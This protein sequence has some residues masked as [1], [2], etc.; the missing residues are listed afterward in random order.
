[1]VGW[2]HRLDE[3]GFGKTP[4]LGVGGGQGGLACCGHTFVKA[5]LSLYPFLDSLLCTID[6]II[7]LYFHKYVLIA[8]G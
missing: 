1:M 2:H 4:N 8:V 3:H 7:S 6:L 5:Q